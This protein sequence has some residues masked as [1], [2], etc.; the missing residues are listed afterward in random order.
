MAQVM[1][2]LRSQ[3]SQV[4]IGEDGVTTTL[5]EKAPK[6][7]ENGGL[8]L[9]TIPT[10]CIRNCKNSTYTI[11]HRIS[12][13]LIEGCENVTVNVNGKIM[14][15]CIEAWKC[16]NL[17]IKS[18][19]AVKTLQ[20]DLSRCMGLHVPSKDDL[21][22]VVWQ[23]VEDLRITFD[24][25]HS[26]YDLHTGFQHMKETYPDSEINLDQFIIRFVDELGDFLSCER[27]IRLKNGFLATDREAADWERRNEIAKERYVSG[28][29]KQAGV[30]LNKSKE[31]TEKIDRNGP[32]PCHSGKKYK[33]CCIN[34]KSLTGVA[35][36]N[37][38]SLK[39]FKDEGT[40]K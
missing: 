37:P 24:G 18:K 38:E 9:K 29:L 15:C 11:N 30:H 12:K 13:L 25:D 10:V 4:H 35:T 16:T 19:V 33:K 40:K 8:D 17:N 36:D 26:K 6:T 31:K 3:H 2:N 7:D 32:C 1:E 39:T 23:D 20:A 28:F 22:C 34:K 5:E 27:A 14:T 21:N